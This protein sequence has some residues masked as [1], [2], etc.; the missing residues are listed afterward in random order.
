MNI[1]NK[2]TMGNTENIERTELNDNQAADVTGGSFFDDVK[3][4]FG[5]H[6]W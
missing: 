3:C 1:E 5:I 4:F 6:E 2:E